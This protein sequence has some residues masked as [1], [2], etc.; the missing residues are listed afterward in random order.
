MTIHLAIGDMA[1]VKITTEALRAMKRDG[2]KI[3]CLT[4]YDHLM[5][6]ILD[7]AGVDLLIV[8]DSVGTVMQGRD[9]TV[10]VTMEQMV[11][12][13]EMVSRAAQRAF[14]VVDM[15]FLSYQVSTEEALRNAGRMLKEGL[16]EAV[17]VEGGREIAELVRRLTDAGIPVMGHLGLMPQSIHK[18]GT[19]KVRGAD[20]QESDRILGDAQALED[21]GAFG[22][23]LEKI[24]SDLGREVTA[25]VG[26]PT[27]GIGA[28]PFTDGQVLVSHDMLGLFTRFRPRF[29]RRYAELS[30]QMGEAVSRFC[31]DV[32]GGEF[33]GSDES[34]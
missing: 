32:R 9:T 31:A 30:D 8:G 15:P 18:Y 4:A 17:K 27:I 19:Y 33:P 5:A 21:A 24:P 12:H 3:V 22:M 2:E 13:C 10:S 1:R 28:G 26:I 34:Y 20:P 14:V 29:V 6:G 16:T 11:Y 25:Q 23:V 7:R